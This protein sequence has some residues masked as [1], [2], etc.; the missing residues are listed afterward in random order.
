MAAIT[1]HHSSRSTLLPDY[2]SFRR[3]AG[4]AASEA[5]LLNLVRVLRSFRNVERMYQ[6][7]RSLETTRI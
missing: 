2:N 7:C 6:T 5:M 1:S 4:N 3:N